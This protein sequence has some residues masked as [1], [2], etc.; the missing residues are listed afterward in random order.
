MSSPSI[1]GIVVCEVGSCCPVVSLMSISPFS[2]VSVRSV[3]RGE[4]KR[5]AGCIVSFSELSVSLSSAG[6]SRF[7]F[8]EDDVEIFDSSEESLFLFVFFVGTGVRERVS[9][10][11]L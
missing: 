1:V 7:S 9:D 3:T 2:P 10:L 8:F 5:T 6:M 4:L 11:L